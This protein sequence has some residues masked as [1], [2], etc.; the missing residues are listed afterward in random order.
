MTPFPITHLLGVPFHVLSEEEAIDWVEN[1]IRNRQ[2]AWACTPNPEIVMACHRDSALAQA[3]ESATL[4]LPDGV[5]LF[6]AARRLKIPLRE[7]ITG[8]DLGEKLIARAS[9]H[10]HRIFFM[11]GGEGIADSAATQMIRKYPNFHVAGTQHGYFTE[12]EEPKIVEAIRSA[13]PDILFVGLGFPRQEIFLA[14]H[15]HQMGVP[16][17]LTVGGAFD[18]WSGRVTRAP[19]FIQR[20]GIEWIFRLLQN[21]SR[22]CRQLNLLKFIGLVLRSPSSL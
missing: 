10:G 9:E 17:S 14:R 1:R 6:W 13:H 5:A 12:N 3:I 15:S 16:F 18:V 11:G 2:P 22:I 20:L 4:S 8:I 19:R 21:P 7:K